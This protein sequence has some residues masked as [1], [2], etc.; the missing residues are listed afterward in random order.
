[1][2]L[3]YQYCNLKFLLHISRGVF[4]IVLAA[5]GFG[6]PMDIGTHQYYYRSEQ[7]L[8]TE[9]WIYS[10]HRNELQPRTSMRRRVHVSH[11]VAIGCKTRATRRKK[12]IERGAWRRAWRFKA[13][14]SRRDTRRTCIERGTFDDESRSRRGSWSLRQ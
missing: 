3:A 14:H 4:G 13:V 2:Y 1:M 11:S 6:T 7:T 8:R 9:T 5:K 12:S 10:G